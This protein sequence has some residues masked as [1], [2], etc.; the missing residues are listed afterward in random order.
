MEVA[1]VALVIRFGAWRH[2]GLVLAIRFRVSIWGLATLWE[3][4]WRLAVDLAFVGDRHMLGVAAS[5]LVQVG[6]DLYRFIYVQKEDNDV[7]KTNE[8]GVLGQKIFITTVRCFIF[9]FCFHRSRNQ[10]NPCSSIAGS[11]DW[12]SSF[13]SGCAVGDLAGPCSILC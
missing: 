6:I 1:A 4:W 11:M 2:C 8:V 3:A 5:W 7:D 9:N 12:L 10:C 13:S